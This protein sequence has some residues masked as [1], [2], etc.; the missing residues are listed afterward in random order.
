MSNTE[1]IRRI[2]QEI[3]KVL[4]QE[5]KPS[6]SM[7]PKLFNRREVGGVRVCE[8]YFKTSNIL[9]FVN[10]MNRLGFYDSVLRLRSYID[11]PEVQ[12]EFDYASRQAFLDGSTWNRY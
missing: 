1:D 9:K 6:N 10:A 12:T 8:E 3:Y 11:D 7:I 4:Q 2:I 5:C